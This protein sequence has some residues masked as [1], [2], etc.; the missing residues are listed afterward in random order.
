MHTK[1]VSELSI[2]DLRAPEPEPDRHHHRTISTLQITLTK[3]RMHTHHLLIVRHPQSQLRMDFTRKMSLTEAASTMRSL[4]ERV[5]H[6]AGKP[7]LMMSESSKMFF[8]V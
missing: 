2:E 5:P 4:H 6:T 8:Q 3:K 1:Q 7:P